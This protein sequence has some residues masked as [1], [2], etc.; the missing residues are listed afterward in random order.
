MEIISP[1]GMSKRLYSKAFNDT[2]TFYT[3][4]S[5]G[6]LS[7]IMKVSSKG[8]PAASARTKTMVRSM[9]NP[10]KNPNWRDGTTDTPE[11]KFI[12]STQVTWT[13]IGSG[14]I[15]DSLLTMGQGNAQS[16]RVGTRI[17]AKQIVIRAKFRRNPTTPTNSTIRILVFHW[18][19]PTL[20][21]PTAAIIL[22][23]ATA[24]TD[25]VVSPLNLFNTKRF[26]ILKDVTQELD[27]GHGEEFFYQYATSL[28]LSCQYT[29]G[30]SPTL[31]SSGD[32]Y[33]MVL[34]ERFNV[35]DTQIQAI[36]NVRVRY[37][38]N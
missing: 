38:D 31:P 4:V 32:I 11:K 33:F 6:A 15:V 12:D 28:N 10:R 9:G 29:E 8:G 30:A 1:R 25:C 7:K 5:S 19:D 21:P 2:S 14:G 27:L 3:P 22:Q 36:Y 18:H 13:N 20:S 37:I 26:K 17:L 35:S 23:F 16:Q 34:D 24:G